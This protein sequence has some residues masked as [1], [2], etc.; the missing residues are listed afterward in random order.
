[1]EQNR[2]LRE[3]KIESCQKRTRRGFIE[4]SGR[5]KLYQQRAVE[6]RMQTSFKT[7]R[8][9]LETARVCA[10]AEV[11]TIAIIAIIIQIFFFPFLTGVLPGTQLQDV[12][13]AGPRT[14]LFLS[15][16]FI[17]FIE[18]CTKQCVCKCTYPTNVKKGTSISLAKWRPTRRSVVEITSI[19]TC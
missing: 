2:W 19:F 7:G 11:C 4:K 15:D 17:L 16:K 10:L 6:G 8:C 5:K 12:K 13:A 9:G 3:Y 1:M 14:C 18:A